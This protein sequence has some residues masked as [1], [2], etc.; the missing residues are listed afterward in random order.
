MA[1]RPTRRFGAHKGKHA[2]RFRHDIGRS[3]AFNVKQK[4]MR[5]GWR[6]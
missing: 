2:R 4:P 6:L 3:H 5:G 1:I